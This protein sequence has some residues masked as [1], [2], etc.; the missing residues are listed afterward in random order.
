MRLW[1]QVQPSPEKSIAPSKQESP[2]TIKRS[3][4]LCVEIVV[5]NLNSRSI[6]HKSKEGLSSTRRLASWNNSRCACTAVLMEE[7]EE[8]NA[9]GKSWTDMNMTVPQISTIKVQHGLA[10]I[11]MARLAPP[12]AAFSDLERI[13]ILTSKIHHQLF[14]IV[15]SPLKRNA[16]QGLTRVMRGSASSKRWHLTTTQSPGLPTMFWC[17]TIA[18]PMVSTASGNSP[19]TMSGTALMTVLTGLV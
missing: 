5:M 8:E 2:H 9:L 19:T 17:A 11:L 6:A 3:L 13:M 4:K 16:I 15:D 10:F 18:R 14:L 1:W 7:E 12:P